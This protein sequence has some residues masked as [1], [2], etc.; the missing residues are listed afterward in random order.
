MATR[1]TIALEYAD[2]TVDQVY[3]HWDGYLDNNGKILYK[4]YVDPFKVQRLMDLG[5]ISSLG[6]EVGDAH[7]FDDRDSAGDGTTFYGRDRGEEGT[8]AKR[9]KDFAD[10]EKNH[11]YEEYEYVL[12][13]DG[14]WYVSQYGRSY[15][16]L[17]D[18]IANEMK[19]RAD[20]EALM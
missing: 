12:R 8:G 3:C 6:T 5:D 4:H 9:F 20:E 18:A 17:G 15:E 16:L 14:H 11:Q 1:S 10:Y 13:R 7:D 19:E 2:G